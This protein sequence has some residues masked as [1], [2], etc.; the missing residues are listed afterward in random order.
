MISII[1]LTCDQLTHQ[2][3]TISESRKVILRKIASYI[4]EKI[5]KNEPI[6]LE[7]VCTHNSRRSHFGQIWGK[8]AAEY[9]G[10][11]NV[12]TYSA[13]TEATAMHPHTVQ[14]LKNQGFDINTDSSDSNPCYSVSFDETQEPLLC[15]SKTVDHQSNPSDGFAAI[16]T[17]SEAE[18]N[19]P[20]LPGAEFRISTTYEDPKEYDGTPLQVQKYI[21]RSQQIARENLYIFSLIK[22]NS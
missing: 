5:T 14:T 22:T 12:L 3:D 20:F 21:D 16:M 2:F 13:G 19:C 6:K 8:V 11:K 17:C 7:F 9:Y 1:K 10:I 18:V 15:F 4:Q